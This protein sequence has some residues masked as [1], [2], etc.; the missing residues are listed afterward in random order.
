MSRCSKSPSRI[1]RRARRPESHIW[2]ISSHL[3][4]SQN[5]LERDGGAQTAFS[6]S[7]SHLSEEQ[8]MTPE[9]SSEGCQ[10]EPAE[11]QSST[12]VLHPQPG[13]HQ[14]PSAWISL[15]EPG[16]EELEERQEAQDEEEEEMEE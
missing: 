5:I 7:H 11:S 15:D 2:Q 4:N 10:P 16:S 6:H 13:L 14:P 12:L 8:R 9:S 3:Q 1:W